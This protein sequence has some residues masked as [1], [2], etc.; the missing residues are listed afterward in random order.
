[1]ITTPYRSAIGV[2]L[3]AA[4]I[5][6]WL[7]LGVG[8]IGKDGDPANLM[9]FGVLAVGIIGAIFARFQPHGMARALVATALAQ[10]LV[11]VIALTARLGL[12]WSGPAEILALNGFF[13]ALFVGSAWLFRRSA[14]RQPPGSATSR[15]GRQG[16]T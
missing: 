2:A 3:A 14:R 9:Y 16:L 8:I 13:V 7:S 6:V 15:A 12:P 11:T 5:L 10:T 1:M 4:F